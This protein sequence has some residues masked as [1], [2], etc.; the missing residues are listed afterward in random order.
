MIL[1]FDIETTAFLG[2]APGEEPPS[3]PLTPL[4]GNFSVSM[5][6]ESKKSLLE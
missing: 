2:L 5:C 3:A 4:V 6:A 1:R